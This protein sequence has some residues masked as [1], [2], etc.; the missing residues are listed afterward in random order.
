MINIIRKGVL[1]AG[2]MGLTGC[3]SYNDNVDKYKVNPSLFEGTDALVADKD[4]TDQ[5][6]NNAT[7]EE[8][9][10]SGMTRIKSMADLFHADQEKTKVATTFSATD[11]VKF[12]V[13]AMKLL[14]SIFQKS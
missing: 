1:L 14:K 3:A 9:N 10:K 5:G 2:L 13:D 11:K 7:K 8:K 6:K 12:S 4:K